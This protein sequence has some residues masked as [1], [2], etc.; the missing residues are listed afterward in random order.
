MFPMKTADKKFDILRKK[1]NGKSI[2]H[3]T[4]PK[5]RTLFTVYKSSDKKKVNIGK[6]FRA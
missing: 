5:K 1:D 3:A 2:D 6:E 4:L